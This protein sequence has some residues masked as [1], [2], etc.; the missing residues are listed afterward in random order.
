[1]TSALIAMLMLAAPAHAQRPG[2]DGIPREPAPRDPPPRFSIARQVGALAPIGLPLP[3]IGLRPRRA[4]EPGRRLG[5]VRS[6]SGRWCS[7]CRSRSWRRRLQSPP[8][9]CREGARA[10]AADSRR[11]TG[12]SAGLCRWLLRRATRRFQRCARRRASRGRTAPINVNAAGYE[13]MTLDLRVTASQPVTVRAALKTLPPP[14]AMPRTTFYLIPGC[15]MGNIPPRD[16][17]LP[18]TCD[19]SRVVTWVP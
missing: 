6:R 5:T 14:V 8:P 1:M 17:G 4:A 15:Y 18:A 12:H 11:R 2:A 10:G 16:A 9:D 7:T 3:Q 19:Q 13:P